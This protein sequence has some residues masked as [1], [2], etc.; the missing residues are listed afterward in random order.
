MLIQ[1][2]TVYLSYPSSQISSIQKNHIHK[3][4]L[5]LLLPVYT[6][7]CY[8]YVCIYIYIYAYKCMYIYIYCLATLCSV[9]WKVVRR[10]EL[11]GS[12]RRLC[13]FA[14]FRFFSFSSSHQRNS[15]AHGFF[16]HQKCTLVIQHSYGKSPFVMGKITINGHF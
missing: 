6:I 9:F 8:I 16:C 10:K 11:F 1:Y 15:W 7:T 5:V 14:F 3:W 13:V 2:R 4:Y 12:V